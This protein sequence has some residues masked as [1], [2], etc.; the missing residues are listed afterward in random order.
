MHA[1]LS[2]VRGPPRYRPVVS[3]NAM[4]FVTTPPS[5]SQSLISAIPVS[6]MGALYV[7]PHRRSVSAV[8]FPQENTSSDLVSES[9]YSLMVQGVT[10]QVGESAV[11]HITVSAAT[12]TPSTAAQVSFASPQRSVAPLA[13]P[14]T[15][16]LSDMN[17]DTSLDM[18]T[19]DLA[20]SRQPPIQAIAAMSTQTSPP[21]SG[22]RLSSPRTPIQ[23]PPAVSRGQLADVLTDL[24]IS[25]RIGET[26][27]MSDESSRPRDIAPESPSLRQELLAT[28]QIVDRISDH[29]DKFQRSINFVSDS[30]DRQFDIMSK[31]QLDDVQR[32]KTG[33]QALNTRL[34]SLEESQAR[35]DERLDA[36]ENTRNDTA[37]KQ[38]AQ[39]AAAGTSLNAGMLQE[40][41]DQVQALGNLLNGLS[42]RMD[43]F[44][45][46]QR[47][48]AVDQV[49]ENFARRAE[50]AETSPGTPPPVRR[51]ANACQ[52]ARQ[53]DRPNARQDV[54]PDARQDAR[55]DIC[56]DARQD[57]RQDARFFSP[58]RRNSPRRHSPRRN[59][60][61]RNSPRRNS[62]RRTSPR[63]NSP[64]PRG[65]GWTNPGPRFPVNN[66]TPQGPQMQTPPQYGPPPVQHNHNAPYMQPPAPQNYNNAQY[67]PPPVQNNNNIA[68]YVPQPPQNNMPGPPVNVPFPYA[69][70]PGQNFP[71][72][73]IPRGPRPRNNGN[74]A[75]DN[76]GYGGI[77]RRDIMKK[78]ER[79][80]KFRGDGSMSWKTFI[81]YFE[82]NCTK[83]Q[84]DDDLKLELLADGLSGTAAEFFMALP[85]AVQD[86]YDSLVTSLQKRFESNANARSI[87]Q[88]LRSLKQK[89]DETIQDFSQRVRLVVRDLPN[90]QD[91]STEALAVDTFLEGVRNSTAALFV[92]QKD[93]TSLERAVESLD[94]TI[95]NHNILAAE[96][97]ARQVDVSPSPTRFDTSQVR[98]V[99]S[100]S[101]F[102]SPRRSDSF[103]NSR[104]PG[105]H[106]SRSPRRDSR[107]RRD[108]RF[109]PGR[110]SNSRFSQRSFSPN[111]RFRSRRDNFQRSRSPSVTSTASE[112]LQNALEQVLKKLTAVT[113]GNDPNGC[114]HC[115]RRGHFARE[116]PEKS[117]RPTSPRPP[118]PPTPI[119]KTDERDNR[120]QR[121]SR[122]VAFDKHQSNPNG[123]S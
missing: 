30:M 72:P 89:P 33:I 55:Q 78:F 94:Q 58:P 97:K 29:I 85:T 103:R 80:D 23:N 52:D 32:L 120:A 36:L 38:Q 92:M 107:D 25:D 104:S 82:K 54:R 26:S 114:F 73:V 116:C 9:D 2:S 4:P 91:P 19:H 45:H 21:C 46:Q 5:Y 18:T 20:D 65:Y 43:N 75:L 40:T 48:A 17:S 3:P 8:H 35:M 93:H 14:E 47:V 115:G 118:L 112:D 24:D 123:S 31:N 67:A 66:N 100:N 10:E 83:Y 42:T 56:P 6:S 108:N 74:G 81:G 12:V 88:K 105:R 79:M 95:S 34:T 90:P 109:S 101:R 49:N 11:P 121:S 99:N 1:D 119:L 57:A 110:D 106:W 63:R 96:K 22:L 37:V 61:R 60:P 13:S 15:S 113:S 7:P 50:P 76:T 68:Q 28:R 102:Q 122:N 87:R 41:Y 84:C 59:S 44:E 16:L 39:A 70:P 98:Q 77:T 64:Q 27:L 51:H 53:D 117:P 71:H 62:P 86:D 69:P 111:D